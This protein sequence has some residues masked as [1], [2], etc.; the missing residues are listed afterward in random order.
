VANA[1][2]TAC[3]ESLATCGGYTAG[4]SGGCT[5]SDAGLCYWYATTPAC[6]PITTANTDCAKVTGTGLTKAK[7]AAYNGD[8]VAN[9]AGTAC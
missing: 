8:C 5:K 3:Q 7:C 4:G 9:A 1:A 2:G 6:I